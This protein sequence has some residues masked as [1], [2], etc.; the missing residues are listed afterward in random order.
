MG[1][2]IHDD[3]TMV[4]VVTLARHQNNFFKKRKKII[5]QEKNSRK[6]IQLRS[7]SPRT[8]DDT[9]QQREQKPSTMITINPHQ[10]VQKN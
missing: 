9:T 3:T 7:H 5:I 4:I 1:L 2:V 6:V 8:M 10:S